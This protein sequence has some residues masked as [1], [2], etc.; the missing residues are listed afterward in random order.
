MS[1]FKSEKQHKENL[2]LLGRT[3]ALVVAS[4]VAI[5]VSIG[6]NLQTSPQIPWFLGVILVCGIFIVPKVRAVM[7]AFEDNAK[8]TKT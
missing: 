2:K 7:K 4:F 8:T 3:G 1:N 5:F 6:V